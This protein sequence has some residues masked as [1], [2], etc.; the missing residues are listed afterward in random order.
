M[1]FLKHQLKVLSVYG[2]VIISIVLRVIFGYMLEPVCGLWALA[3]AAS[4]G[5]AVAMVFDWICVF[6]DPKNKMYSRNL[7]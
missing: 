7:L 2:I 1:D 3:I 5:N 4:I 6:A